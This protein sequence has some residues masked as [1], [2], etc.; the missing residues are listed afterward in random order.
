MCVEVGVS[1]TQIKFSFVKVIN[2]HFTIGDNFKL[3]LS[4]Q[5]KPKLL[6]LSRFIETNSKSSEFRGHN[7][8][9]YLELQVTFD[10]NCF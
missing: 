2:F 10:T 7:F 3:S 4:D 9:Q 6:T 5:I 8:L 1:K